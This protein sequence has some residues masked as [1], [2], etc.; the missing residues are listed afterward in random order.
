MIREELTVQEITAEQAEAART[1]WA[2]IVTSARWAGEF[3]PARDRYEHAVA[4]AD[5]WAVSI[6]SDKAEFVRA[7]ES[8]YWHAL[9]VQAYEDHV[10]QGIEARQADLDGPLGRLESASVALRDYR[11]GENYRGVSTALARG[12]DALRQVHFA[13]S[14][15]QDEA[16]RLAGELSVAAVADEPAPASHLRLVRA[17]ERA[18]A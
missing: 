16:H 7:C 8:G 12:F 5:E 3:T 4:V 15:L 6:V 2:E 9:A 10:P 13:L 14:T 17:E 11:L 1:R 18:E